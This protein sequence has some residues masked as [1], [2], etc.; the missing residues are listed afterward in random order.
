MRFQATYVTRVHGPSCLRCVLLG[1]YVNVW[2]LSA[3][4][5]VLY[6]IS[7]DVVTEAEQAY[8]SLF[9]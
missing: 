9:L 2:I 7:E 6:I 5:G 4:H 1:V 8:N 3:G